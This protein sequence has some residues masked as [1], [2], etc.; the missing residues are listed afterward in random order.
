MAVAEDT[1]L[2]KGFDPIS[3]EYGETIVTGRPFLQWPPYPD[4]VDYSVRVIRES[5]SRFSRGDDGPRITETSVQVDVNL[6]LGEYRWRVDA[7]NAEGHIIGC[8]YYLKSNFTVVHTPTPTPTPTLAP[9]LPPTS[10]PTST[11]T[12]MPMLTPLPLGVYSS[13]TLDIPQTWAADLDRG[14][15]TSDV[16]ADS[17]IW[18]ELRLRGYATWHRCLG[19]KPPIREASRREGRGVSLHLSLLTRFY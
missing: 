5:V 7:F 12:P 11:P 14:V 3:P 15:L 4:A 16:G 1:Y 13:G 10:T 18:S 9:T 17:D 6:S 8:S 2:C 19:P